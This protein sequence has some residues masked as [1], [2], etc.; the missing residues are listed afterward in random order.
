MV[1]INGQ[2]WLDYGDKYLILHNFVQE[3][4]YTYN[5]AYYIKIYLSCI[6]T[7]SLRFSET[8]STLFVPIHVQVQF[9]Y[10]CTLCTVSQ[11][12]ST[13]TTT[14]VV[15]IILQFFFSYERIS[16]LIVIIYLLN[17]NTAPLRFQI[18]NLEP[19]NVFRQ[20]KTPRLVVFHTITIIA[21]NI[22][23]FSRF[24]RKSSHN[25]VLVLDLPNVRPE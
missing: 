5:I 13:N 2:T 10:T 14:C 25:F 23:R 9:E 15:F 24:V 8:D 20:P 18:S 12:C 4:T 11:I 7:W 1:D 16:L 17:Y 3:Y 21:P 6:L 19:R 22:E